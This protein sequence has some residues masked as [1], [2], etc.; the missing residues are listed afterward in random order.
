ML[1][2]DIEQMR[3][4]LSRVAGINRFYDTKDAQTDLLYRMYY[5]L[6]PAPIEQINSELETE[7]KTD[8]ETT[9]G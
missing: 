9:N 6:T 1:K 3:L 8:L 5:T 4:W 2:N 7:I